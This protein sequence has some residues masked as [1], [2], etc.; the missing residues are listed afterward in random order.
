MER[1]KYLDICQRVS[2]IPCEQF[3]FK[4]VP[5]EFQVRYKGILYYPISYKLS[6]DNFGNA[7]H[8]AVLHDLGTRS[9]VECRL[10]DVEGFE[11][12]KL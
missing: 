9:V 4:I 5:T 2:V 12:E 10:Q 3:S 1:K 8:T 6:F 7:I 11:N